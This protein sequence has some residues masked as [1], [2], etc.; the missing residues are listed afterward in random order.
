MACHRHWNYIV[1]KSLFRLTLQLITLDYFELPL[2]YCHMKMVI[3]YLSHQ[4]LAEYIA[5]I[6]NG[7]I[8]RFV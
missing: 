8:S 1:L 2:H 3:S 6:R 4:N 5:K 7:V